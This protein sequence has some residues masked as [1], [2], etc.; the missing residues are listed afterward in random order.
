MS[1]NLYTS[2]D[3]Y[4]ERRNPR[5]HDKDFTLDE[6]GRKWFALRETYTS[7]LADE[8][9]IWALCDWKGGEQPEEGELINLYLSEK[10]PRK[11]IVGAF[12][13]FISQ[14][15]RF[16]TKGIFCLQKK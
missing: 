13:I 14:V 7:N 16:G 2:H 8:D 1:K 10:V 9:S 12:S 11:A 3:A 5:Q 15:T 6:T 4:S